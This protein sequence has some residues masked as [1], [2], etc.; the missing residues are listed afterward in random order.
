MDSPGGLV[1]EIT[2]ALPL[3]FAATIALLLFRHLRVQQVK[4]AGAGSFVPAAVI[5]A[6]GR[7]SKVRCR[8]GSG[9]IKCNV[10]VEA[11]MHVLPIRSRLPPTD[12]AG[13]SG[14]RDASDEEDKRDNSEHEENLSAKTILF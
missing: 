11:D 7:N 10:P 5:I 4:S 3:P 6:A 2:L 14:I 13:V 12:Y 9:L 1:A 8:G